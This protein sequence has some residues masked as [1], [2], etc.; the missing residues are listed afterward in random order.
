MHD[1]C[2]SSLSSVFN[3]P[4]QVQS[5]LHSTVSD[6]I[7]NHQW[8]IPWQLQQAFP[9]LMSHVNRVTIPIVEKQDQLLWKHSKSGMLSLKDAYK[10]TSTARQKLDWTEIIWNLAITPSKSFMMWRLIHNRMST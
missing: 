2:G 1:W 3:F 9:P 8:H 6:Y 5:N 10:F 4:Q 7:E